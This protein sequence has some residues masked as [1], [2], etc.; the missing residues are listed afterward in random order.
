[1]DVRVAIVA[2]VTFAGLVARR[3]LIQGYLGGYRDGAVEAKGGKALHEP[4]EI[5]WAF[6]N[7]LRAAKDEANRPRTH[8]RV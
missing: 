3:A 5:R 2:G 6:G 7:L 4:F 1:M 8:R